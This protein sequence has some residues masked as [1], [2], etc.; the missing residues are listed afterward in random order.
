MIWQPL[1][2]ENLENPLHLAGRIIIPFIM[3][4]VAGYTGFGGLVLVALLIFTGVTGT[5]INLVKLRLSGMLRRVIVCER[6]KTSL[7]FTYTGTFI[8]LYTLVFFP[9]VVAGAWFEGIS[10]I[11][12]AILTIM[13]A[14][15]CGTLVGVVSR[16]LG[17]V[18][19]YAILVTVPLV[20]LGVVRNPIDI[21]FPMVYV[22]GII[23]L[24]PL[25]GLPPLV[26]GISYGM[27]LIY[28]SRL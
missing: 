20:L 8:L 26:V 4:L 25:W 3:I 5:A 16:G 2:N 7:F 17:G 21:F 9:S 10:I 14:A 27:L 18:H 6:S 22:A 1:I 24:P 13:L 12:Y 23:D 19:L 28:V 11:P 15:I